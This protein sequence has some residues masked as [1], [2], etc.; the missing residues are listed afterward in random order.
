[1]PKRIPRYVNTHPFVAQVIVL[2]AV[3]IGSGLL[4]AN[5]RELN[6]QILES[7]VIAC[8]RGNVLREA[9]IQ[10]V[11]QQK[12]TTKASDPN[13][14]PQ[15]PEEE[16]KLLIQQAVKRLNDQIEVLQPVDCLEAYPAAAELDNIDE[17]LN[18]NPDD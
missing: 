16:F 13:L 1:M 2:I 4:Y 18:T 10:N 15:I 7:Q 9:L 8:T 14:F 17:L 12:I 11:K 6:Q 5:Q 3:M